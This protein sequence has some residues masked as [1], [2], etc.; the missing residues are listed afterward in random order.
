MKNYRILTYGWL[1]DEFAD[2]ANQFEGIE[3]VAFPSKNDVKENIKDF[4]ALAGFNFLKG[5]D[6]EHIEWLHC[7]VAGIDSYFALGA[8]P[9]KMKISRTSGNMGAKIGEYCLAYTLHILKSI[10]E[11]QLRQ[12]LISWKVLELPNLYQKKVL[13]YGTGSIGQG[14]AKVFAPLAKSVVGVNRSGK[15]APYFSEIKS[16]K[17]IQNQSQDEFDVVIN[18]LP[19]TPQTTYF[20]NKDIF[21][22]LHSVIFINIGRG[23]SVDVPDLLSAIAAGNIE[24]AVLDVFEEEPLPANSPLWLNPKVFV[25]PHHSGITDF[26]D[27]KD[28]FTEVY[29]ALKEG[30]SSRLFV[31]R[32]QG[33]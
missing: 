23:L 30:K 7:F 11:A 17:A 31:D 12:K 8:L 14:I 24:Y 16:F 32:I 9:I 28:S 18:A 26:E 1:S 19:L 21:R 10:K 13:I 3:C 29:S 2:F 22:K 6:I 20:F 5:L 25:T 4:N 15:L 33:Y 27:I